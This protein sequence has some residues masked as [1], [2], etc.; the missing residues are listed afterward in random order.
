MLPSTCMEMDQSTQ[1]HNDFLSHRSRMPYRLWLGPVQKYWYKLQMGN[2]QPPT[3][4]HHLLGLLAQWFSQL[5]LCQEAFP[6]SA[7][8]ARAPFWSALES[9][10]RAEYSRMQTHFPLGGEVSMCCWSKYPCMEM[11]WHLRIYSTYLCSYVF[12]GKIDNNV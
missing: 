12:R 1:V 4:G 8:P 3:C 5:L 10:R 11:K 9:L 7:S 6:T 2:R